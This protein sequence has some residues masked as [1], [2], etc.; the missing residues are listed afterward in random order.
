MHNLGGASWHLLGSPWP[1]G[2][3]AR[4]CSGDR[5]FVHAN[6]RRSSG[7]SSRNDPVAAGLIRLSVVLVH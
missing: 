3:V 1:A 5:I 7:D 6:I 4:C 2:P